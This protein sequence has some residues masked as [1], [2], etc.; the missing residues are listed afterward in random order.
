[1][2]AAGLDALLVS[3]L[4][5][6]R[7]LSGFSGSSALVLV[8]PRRAVLVTDF[9]Y[10]LQAAAEVRGFETEEQS[11]SP[12][13]FLRRLLGRLGRRRLGFEASAPYSFARR[14]HRLTGRR[15]R[16]AEGLVER[17]R[18][19]KDAGEIRLL[20]RLV[21]AAAAGWADFTERVRPEMSESEAAL[22]LEVSLR[23]AGSDPPPFPVIM[24]A[25]A[26]AAL[27]H[28]RPG[29]DLLGR[30]RPVIADFGASGGGYATDVT[31]TFFLGRPSAEIAKIYRVVYDAQASAIEAVRPG[32]AASEIDAAARAV[33][34][35]AGMDGLFGHSTGHG[36]GLDVHE[37]PS[38]S[39]QSRDVLRPGMVVTVEPGVYVEGRGGVR[40]E[41]MVLVTR[42]G[43]RVLTRALPK[44][45]AWP[46][47]P[48]GK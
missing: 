25:G 32:A 8:T 44:P 10:R 2:E 35:R 12:D 13:K 29:P 11:G 14:L 7:W 31:R 18:M 36:V 3:N 39:G 28:A 19:V 17:L 9:R 15:P 47:R 6:I 23:R 30:N 38:L 33:T 41:D 21:A 27:P 22:E 26:N 1:M 46:R 45:E 24:A 42:A 20:E 16:P 43:G 34:R 40:I 4:R 5:N 48:G 37:G